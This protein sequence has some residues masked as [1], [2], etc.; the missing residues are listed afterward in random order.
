MIS[1]IITVAIL[2]WAVTALFGAELLEEG[3]PFGAVL[4]FC[5]LWAVVALFI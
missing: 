3:N 1:L 2:C 4:L 5:C